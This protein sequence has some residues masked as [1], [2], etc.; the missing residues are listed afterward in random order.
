LQDWDALTTEFTAIEEDHQLLEEYSFRQFLFSQAE[1]LSQSE[2]ENQLLQE[3][4]RCL[5]EADPDGYFA[6]RHMRHHPK[7]NFQVVAIEKLNGT[8]WRDL[9]EKLAVPI[10]AL[11][12]FYSRSLKD[13]APVIRRYLIFDV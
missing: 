3:R 12:S 5:L 13:F 9:S 10:S 11:A 7:V 8:K 1:I 6:S 2:S 4:L